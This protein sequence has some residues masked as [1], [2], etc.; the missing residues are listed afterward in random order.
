MAALAVSLAYL[1]FGFILL[2]RIHIILYEEP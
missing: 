1:V 2:D